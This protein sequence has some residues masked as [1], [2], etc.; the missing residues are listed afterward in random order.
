[1]SEI[2]CKTDCPS[3]RRSIRHARELLGRT[4]KCPSCGDTIRLVADLVASET[5]TLLQTQA[6]ADARDNVSSEEII[7]GGNQEHGS[8]RK[9]GRFELNRLLGRGGFGEV[10]ESTDTHL[11]RQVAIKLPLFPASEKKK[12]ARFLTEGRAAAQLR[13]PNIVGVFDAGEADG[14]HYLA[15]ELVSGKSLYEFAQNKRLTHA[16]AAQVVA[17]LAKA[18]HYAH[19]NGIVHRDIKPQNIVISEDLEPQILD[20]G[21][22]KILDD[23][24]GLTIDGAVLGTP[25]YM[26]PEQAR[27]EL[28]RIGPLS[29]QYSLGASFFWLLTGRA[30]FEGPHAAVLAQVI[31]ASP[32]KPRDFACELDARLEA[33]CLKS[34]SKLPADRYTNCEELACDLERYLQDDVV[35]ARPVGT[36]GRTLRWASRN[37]TD[38]SLIAAAVLALCG[39]FVFSLSGWRNASALTTVAVESETQA[40]ARLIELKATETQ[41]QAELARLASAKQ[42]SE[43]A[44]IAEVEAQTQAESAQA[45][46]QKQISENEALAKQA[47]EQLALV[48]QNE[49]Q[50]TDLLGGIESA[51]T[52][53]YAVQ[54]TLPLKELSSQLN[55]ILT[56]SVKLI[57]DTQMDAAKQMLKKVSPQFRD[58]RW[59]YLWASTSTNWSSSVRSA[60]Q[61]S[62]IIGIDSAQRLLCFQHGAPLTT[63]DKRTRRSFTW[64]NLATGDEEKNLAEFRVS[65]N[66]ELGNRGVNEA[67]YE[68]GWLNAGGAK[69]CPLPR[70]LAGRPRLWV[71]WDK[72]GGLLIVNGATHYVVFKSVNAPTEQ[73]VAESKP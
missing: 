71:V 11:G 25:A 72:L 38:A 2:K 66:Q 22:A 36:V 9:I 40:S 19:T 42:Q 17:K 34:V 70:E 8:K 12:I 3:C 24:A 51:T 4:V 44:R 65:I 15:I 45:A 63:Y 23:D 28:A 46:L 33:I 31:D 39:S 55:S 54:A 64:V 57:Q 5:E 32:P 13:H 10:W 58:W 53:L 16:D 60:P 1:M 41:M 62:S 37:R 29:D 7:A 59:E 27:G 52:T 67:Q 26:A 35:L 56:E 68:G 20:F 61:N 6:T 69:L 49:F 50:K 73:P 43:Q 14:Q 30:P 47:Q 21:L 48:K 18:L